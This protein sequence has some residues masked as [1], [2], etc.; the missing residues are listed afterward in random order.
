MKPVNKLALWKDNYVRISALL[1][2][3]MSSHF[4]KSAESLVRKFINDEE[5]VDT[6][7]LKQKIHDVISCMKKKKIQVYRT[8]KSRT[9]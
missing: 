2:L 8:S 4:S 9:Q 5:Q 7:M 3:Q 6:Q 1:A